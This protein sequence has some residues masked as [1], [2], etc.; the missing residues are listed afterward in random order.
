MSLLLFLLSLIVNTL[1]LIIP[2]WPDTIQSYFSLS[3]EYTMKSFASH[4]YQTE[5]FYIAIKNDKRYLIAHLSNGVNAQAE[6]TIMSISNIIP[7]NNNFYLT[8]NEDM[9]IYIVTISE[10]NLI[11]KEIEKYP[12][13]PKGNERMKMFFLPNMDAIEVFFTNNDIMYNVNYMRKGI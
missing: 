3:N 11:I 1:C 6:T 8:T 5:H 4:L 10:R 13:T 9:I 2:S 7:A 12:I